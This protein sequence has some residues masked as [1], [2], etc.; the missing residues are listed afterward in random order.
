MI[1]NFMDEHS[2]GADALSLT[3][4]DSQEPYFNTRTGAI[5]SARE[6][7]AI[8]SQHDE[9][10]HAKLLHGTTTPDHDEP[11]SPC[12][13]ADASL[14]G[15]TQSSIDRALHPNHYLPHAT[16]D[17]RVDPG[18][19]SAPHP[20]EERDP[21]VL[22]AQA[23]AL[24]AANGQK[25]TP[26]QVILI[27]RPDV[28][29]QKLIEETR[30]AKQQQQ[31]KG[32]LQQIGADIKKF[33]ETEK[34]KSALLWGADLGKFIEEQSWKLNASAA[35]NAGTSAAAAEGNAEGQE[36]RKKMDGFGSDPL[37]LATV[38]EEPVMGESRN[39]AG[40][41]QKGT[42]PPPTSS[43]SGEYPNN[44]SNAGITSLW[45]NMPTLPSLN[46]ASL[47][48]VSK[49][50]TSTVLKQS[51]IE[52]EDMLRISGVLWK[53]R[54]G[55]GKHSTIK[56]WERRVVELRGSKLMYYKTPGEE[57]DEEN[58]CSL[59]DSSEEESSIPS[60]HN[61]SINTPSKRISIFEQAANTAEHKL[62]SARD[63]L[64]RMAMAAGIES[65][66]PNP[67][68]VPRGI[69]DI[70]KEGATVAAS[71]GHSGSP[72]P[73][74]VSIKVK[75][76]TKWKFCFESH[77]MMMEWL[78][79]L[80]DV[81]VRSSVEAMK[82]ADTCG[83]AGDWE[84]QDYSIAMGRKGDTAASDENV[85]TQ[86]ATNIDSRQVAG[87]MVPKQVV[88]NR[89]ASTVFA[90][91]GRVEDFALR[92]L[93]LKVVCF[94]SNFALLLAR[95]SALSIERY[96]TMMVLMNFV[97][98]QLCTTS[99]DAPKTS[100]GV[101]S[102]HSVELKS[103]PKYVSPEKSRFF[104][105]KVKAGSSCLKVSSVE[106]S[107]MTENGSRLPTWL[108]G[109]PYDLEVR[110]HGY[111]TT[112]RKIPSPGELYE[113]IAVDCFASD[114][115]YSDIA[116]RVVLPENEFKDQDSCIRWK[117]PDLF[118]VSITIPTEAPKFGMGKNSD[119][120]PGTTIV[121][122][123]RM[124]ELTRSILQRITADGYDP[125]TDD[126]E[127]EMDVQKR[128]TNGV[129][130]WEQYCKQAPTDSNFQARF[131][132]IPHVNLSELGCPS[133]ISKY[134]GKPVLIK[135][136]GI[137]GFLSEYPSLNAME[138]DISLHPFPFL[139]KQAM[140]YLKEN[141][142]DKAVGTFGFV[143]EGRN[144]NELPEVVIGAMQICYP[145][146]QYVVSSYEFFG[147]QS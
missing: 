133:Y 15:P 50:T 144:D 129:R 86:D 21:V 83:S 48:P 53:R 91:D 115:R 99:I 75:S 1:P 82:G 137:T 140:A 67:S 73:F 94:M 43:S 128:M 46:A 2:E 19:D 131:K 27:A 105:H 39:Y 95:S 138:F 61:N 52:E 57:V 77:G 42:S 6:A 109:S 84:M 63:E 62:Q 40:Q 117:S 49:P 116:L 127:S 11:N 55:L 22:R 68:N 32:N 13:N 38:E 126:A 122:Y 101:E 93:Q 20:D 104:T 114:T 3:S 96:W 65:L 111:L 18:L 119:D 10:Y 71:R 108:P 69:L 145:N 72:T 100:D 113:C 135:R 14:S 7:W 31:H 4:E 45:S 139:F 5:L 92:G 51:S 81:V 76:E 142:F 23:M 12:S 26:E 123:F 121:G 78:T 17:H 103:T 79:A 30:K 107:N 97:M 85:D 74:C 130:L 16:H 80:T 8:L 24:A 59:L 90:S 60:A 28:Q 120:G 37:A 146:P 54:S 47:F 143:I 66:K 70:V 102:E 132:L 89:S 112:K 9:R 88:N 118:V 35:A 41:C 98:Y 33:I 125:A 134:N 36:K 87:S 34:E 110:S 141:Y 64:S 44:S 136:N 56:A 106:D 124:K 29:Q 58:K 147:E 25:L